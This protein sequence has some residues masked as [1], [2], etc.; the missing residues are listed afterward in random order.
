MLSTE[1]EDSSESGEVIFDL[2]DAMAFEL[3]RGDEYSAPVE[4]L[5]FSV[6]LERIDQSDEMK[7]NIE[8]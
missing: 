2:S 8:F 5:A 7:M 3:R 4:N 1:Q 6:F